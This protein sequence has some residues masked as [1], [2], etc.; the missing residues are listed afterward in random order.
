MPIAPETPPF[1]V[2]GICCDRFGDCAPSLPFM[3]GG[4]YERL[5]PYTDNRFCNL[6][7]RRRP[8]LHVGKIYGSPITQAADN[9]IG[10]LSIQSPPGNRPRVKDQ[11]S[12]AQAEKAP[13]Q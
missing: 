1:P 12:A 7:L 13:Q 2:E 11:E 8:F 4:S 6:P 5:G 10:F 3:I 9:S